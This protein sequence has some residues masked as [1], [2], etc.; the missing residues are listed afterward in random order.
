MIASTHTATEQPEQLLP[1]APVLTGP[2]HRA[3]RA[4]SAVGAGRVRAVLQPERPHRTLGL[5]TPQLK[6]RPTTGIVRSH[7]VV[8]GLHTTF[9]NGQPEHDRGFAAPLLGCAPAI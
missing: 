2:R 3:G 7:P 4:A 1:A 9:T 6:V 5:L 8:N